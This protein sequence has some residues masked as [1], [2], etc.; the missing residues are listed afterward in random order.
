MKY[1]TNGYPLLG[2]LYST[3]KQSETC[4]GIVNNVI[5]E[6]QLLG[7]VDMNECNLDYV[8]GNGDASDLV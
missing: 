1:A 7:G 2:A 3:Q 5:V 6:L 4:M 8:L